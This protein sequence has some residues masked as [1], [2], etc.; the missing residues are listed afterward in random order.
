MLYTAKERDLGGLVGEILVDRQVE[1]ID[2]REESPKTIHLRCVTRDFFHDPDVQADK[3][4]EGHRR[5]KGVG[6]GIVGFVG[7]DVGEGFGVAKV[8][9]EG[10]LQGTDSGE[11]VGLWVEGRMGP[12]GSSSAYHVGHKLRWVKWMRNWRDGDGDEMVMETREE[13]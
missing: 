10:G 3:R 4:T 7:G 9:G 6:I 11:E 8:G 2:E 12:A 1:R 5:V 13:T